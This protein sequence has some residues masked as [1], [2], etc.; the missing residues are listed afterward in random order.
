MRLLSIFAE[1]RFQLS[2]GVLS[3]SN[4]IQIRFPCTSSLQSGGLLLEY[5]IGAFEPEKIIGYYVRGKQ[6]GAP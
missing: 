2:T 4:A 6:Q 3:D 5:L 1:N